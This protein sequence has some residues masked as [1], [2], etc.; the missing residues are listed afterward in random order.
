MARTSYQRDKSPLHQLFDPV[1]HPS[2][3][4]VDPSFTVSDVCDQPVWTAVSAVRLRSY[5]VMLGHRNSTTAVKFET[6]NLDVRLVTHGENPVCIA[7][8]AGLKLVAIEN[9]SV[10]QR[11]SEVGSEI[12]SLR[13]EVLGFSRLDGLLYSLMN[14]P[15]NRS[16]LISGVVLVITKILRNSHSTAD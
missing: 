9:G 1:G 11:L 13:K 16:F 4:G 8:H 5:K 12:T 7:L 2:L 15:L 6:L 14:F 10:R 3:V